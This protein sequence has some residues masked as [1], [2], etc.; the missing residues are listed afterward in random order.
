MTVAREPAARP[1]LQSPAAWYPLYAV[2][3]SD[4]SLV[5]IVL[6]PACSA[7]GSSPQHVLSEP[8]PPV[9][10]LA[11]LPL[12]LLP[13]ALQIVSICRVD[14]IA[15]HSV[16]TPPAAVVMH[17]VLSDA[18]IAMNVPVV[19]QVWSSEQLSLLPPLLLACVAPASSLPPLPPVVDELHATA[20][21]PTA[22]E[23]RPATAAAFHEFIVVAPHLSSGCPRK[24]ASVKAAHTRTF[25]SAGA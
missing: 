9:P 11:L 4:G 13:D 25:R 6:Q 10:V 3:H 16:A 19:Q 23:R 5:T 8:Q 22:T 24:A 21:I 7:V 14:R 15:A 17:W 20:V 12:P 2:A 1:Y 18:S